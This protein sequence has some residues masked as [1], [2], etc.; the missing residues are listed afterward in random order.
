MCPAS[1]QNTGKEDAIHT[2]SLTLLTVT[3]RVQNA[4]ARHVSRDM[5]SMSRTKAFVGRDIANRIII[6]SA[7]RRD[8]KNEWFTLYA[9]SKRYARQLITVT[10]SASLCM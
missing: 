1:Q 4:F 8:A 3:S 10:P 5:T 7:E 9:V 6:H 2:E